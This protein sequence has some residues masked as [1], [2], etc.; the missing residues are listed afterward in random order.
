MRRI[1]LNPDKGNLEC[2]DYN[3]IKKC[4]VP[5]SHF[6]GKKGGLYFINHFNNVNKYS[7]NYETFGIKVI[8]PGDSTG[9]G[10]ISKFSLGLFALLC[11]LAL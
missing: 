7:A 9:S 10:R 8:L 3:N 5:K 6:D 2:T 4:K 11:F 1:T